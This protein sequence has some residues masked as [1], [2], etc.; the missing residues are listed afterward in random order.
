MVSA[1]QT[2][3]A[4]LNPTD[5]LSQQ[6]MSNTLQWLLTVAFVSTLLYFHCLETVFLSD[7]CQVYP[8]T[9]SNFSAR[10][11]RNETGL[12]NAFRPCRLN[13]FQL[14]S[15]RGLCY[16]PYTSNCRQWR[17]LQPSFEEEAAGV[18]MLLLD[19]FSAL[20]ELTQASGSLPSPLLAPSDDDPLASINE[21]SLTLAGSQVEGR[22]VM[23]A[24][25]EDMKQAVK[26]IRHRQLLLQKYITDVVR[27]FVLTPGASVMNSNHTFHQNRHVHYYPTSF[28]GRTP[29]V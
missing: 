18:V 3:L 9:R 19:Q 17:S 24:H 29:A 28:V 26:D 10:P 27:T 7:D 25:L 13:S 5:R 14:W 11:G 20:A 21:V 12:D 4:L 22:F 6:S 8:S 1:H 23:I 15:L 2:H 16:L